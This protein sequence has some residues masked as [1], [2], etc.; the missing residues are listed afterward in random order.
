MHEEDAEVEEGVS[1]ETNEANSA[2]RIEGGN[3]FVELD[4]DH[5]GFKDKEYRE[6]R[7][8]IA[9]IAIEWNKMTMQERRIKKIPN[10]PYSEREHAVWKAIMERVSLNVKR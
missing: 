2:V 5:P 6:R 9:K 10:A 8:E 7:N 1:E 4:P 3:V